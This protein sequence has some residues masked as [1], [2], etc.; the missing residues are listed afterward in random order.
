MNDFIPIEL[1]RII[2]QYLKNNE[3]R[4]LLNTSKGLFKNLKYETVY[5]EI[6]IDSEWYESINSKEFQSFLSFTIESVKDKSKQ[7]SLTINSPVVT[8]EILE[9]CA[10]LI[11][12]IHQLTLFHTDIEMYDFWSNSPTFSL[13]CNIYSVFLGYIEGIDHLTGLTNIKIL[14]LFRSDSIV[15]ID[16]IP[17][18]KRLI[19]TSLPN[20]AEISQY[21][22]IP[23]LK[24]S[25]CERLNLQGLGN[26]E[27]VVLEG[28]SYIRPD[29]L[30]KMKNIKF[31][32]LSLSNLLSDDSKD[33]P[34][35]DKL[36]YLTF[37]AL[38]TKE[39]DCSYFPNL[40]FLEVS[41]TMIRCDHGIFASSLKFTKFVNCYFSDLSVVKDV[42]E[43]VFEECRGEG[44]SNVN[45]LSNACKITFDKIEELDDVSGLGRIYYLNIDHCRKVKDISKLGRVH[46][47]E[48]KYCAITS[49]EGLGEGNSEI[50]FSG[51]PRKF[52]FSPLRSI[53]KV[54]L[55]NC[56]GLVDGRDL[57]NVQ[58]L[59]IY[60]CNNF[61][62]TSALGQ[63]KS[64]LL[65]G[66]PKLQRLVGLENVPHIHLENCYELTDI[67][68]LG[69]QRSLII[70]N[71]RKL[72]EL[73]KADVVKK[74]Y[75]IFQGISLVK[76]DK[77][78]F[79]Y[80]MS[81][82]S[83]DPMMPDIFEMT[84]EE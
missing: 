35:F 2:Q 32:N 37:N 79:C 59:T 84:E 23:E 48:L 41:E 42:K 29:D 10:P 72:N 58:H 71:C 15:T 62:D 60:R 13:F 56:D 28:V 4:N 27:R 82:K 70:Y 17:G 57:T 16:F 18:L 44:F 30:L 39:F 5:Y 51:L 12:G 73:I 34:I 66:C 81:D 61:K 75:G 50:V 43:L 1:L 22:S 47:L 3:Y 68:C 21:G 83:R 8:K 65:L 26:H 53:Y 76:I 38:P 78:S 14:H 52:D 33:F 69:R 77:N 54:T 31:F 64:L 46:R 45:V 6:Y 40:R 36:V 9:H 49:I 11:S 55:N 63:I 7:I 24:I 74:Y 67:D 80:E 19:V 25:N 20:L